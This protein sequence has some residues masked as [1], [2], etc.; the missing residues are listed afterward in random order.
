MP[1]ILASLASFRV[2]SLKKKINRVFRIIIIIILL[3]NQELTERKRIY[4]AWSLKSINPATQE[5][6]AK[7]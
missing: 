6:E 3:F 7:G 5:A 1:W 4:Q 2:I